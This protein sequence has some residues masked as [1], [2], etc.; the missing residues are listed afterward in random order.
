MMQK[1][2]NLA[3]E[4]ERMV[5]NK[6]VK[7]QDLREMVG[8]LYNIVE[9]TKE[10]PEYNNGDNSAKTIEEYIIPRV[11]EALTSLEQSA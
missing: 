8:K 4:A 3:I 9:W 6:E 1:C 10:F 5:S 7:I 11:M 2:D